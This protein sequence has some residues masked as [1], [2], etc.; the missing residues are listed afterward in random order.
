MNKSTIAI[1]VSGTIGLSGMIGGVSAHSN[2]CDFSVNYNINID[3][4]QIRFDKKNGSKIVF[5]GDELMIDGKLVSLTNKQQQ[6]S[7]DF[8]RRTRAVVPKIAQIAVEG[9]ELGVKAATIA[10]T[11]L[12]GNG[13]DVHRDLIEPIEAIS[14]KIKANISE[15]SLNTE[16]LEESFEEDFEDEIEKLVETAISKYSGKM[17]TQIIGSIF[18]GDEEDIKDFEFRME[19]MEHD[20]ERYVE[21]HAE[22]LEEKADELCVDLKAIAEL[23]EQLEEVDGYPKDGI[24][25]EDSDHGF[26]VSGLSIHSD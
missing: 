8:Q 6:T 13:E 24:I 15:T 16:A 25:Q 22:A 10:L 4:Q 12:F 17:I 3:D 14:S 11:G 1:V 21:T 26:K 9:A 7:Q 5:D 2:E 23:D 20:I 19:N 18:S